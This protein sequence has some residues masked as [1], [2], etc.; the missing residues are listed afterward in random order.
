MDEFVSRS[1]SMRCFL[2]LQGPLSPLYRLLGK[3]LRVAGHTV[4]RIN[5]CA[6]DWLH[7]RGEG[8]FSYKGAPEAWKDYIA[9]FIRRENVTD[10]IMHGDRRFYHKVAVDVAA[11]Y[12]VRV[13]ATELGYLRPG[14]MT[15][16]Q[17]GFSTLSHFPADLETIVRI[18]DQVAEPDLT[19]QFPGSFALEAWQDISYHGLN[20]LAGALYPRYR[21][22]TPLHPVIDYAWWARRLLGERRRKVAAMERQRRVLASEEPFFIVPLQV[23]G[24]YQLTAHSPFKTMQKALEVIVHSFAEAASQKARLL[25]K[26]HPLDNGRSNWPARIRHMCE[27]SKLGDRLIFLDGG[28]LSKL[29]PRAQGLVTVNSTAGLEALQ[30]GCAVKTLVPSLYDIEGLTFQGALDDFWRAPSKPDAQLV[31][32]FVRALAA[33]LQERGSIHNKQGVVVAADNIARRILDDR[34]NQPDGFVDPPPR[35]ARALSLGV[36]F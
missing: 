29:V 1:P 32:C 20:V 13:I 16:E 36:P 35:K 10:V 23:E 7:W 30:L 27:T 5:F 31:R 25:V 12:G 4:R 21:R 24:D 3:R 33:T 18:A 6:G 34:L 8:V 19:P 15:V 11:A 22:H 9:E 26:A 17:G 2:F 14:W 28:A